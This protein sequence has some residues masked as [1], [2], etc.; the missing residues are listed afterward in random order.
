VQPSPGPPGSSSACVPSVQ[1]PGGFT[2]SRPTIRLSLV[3]GLGVAGAAL[4]APRP[5]A[6]APDAAAPADP[7]AD[8]QNRWDRTFKDAAK[9]Y[10]N[11]AKKYDTKLEATSAYVR[12]KVLQYLPDDPETRAFLG[13]VKARQADG[14]DDWERNDVIHDKLKDLTD[15]D[16]PK[17]TKFGTDLAAADLKIANWFKGLALK[18]T[19]NGNAKGASADAKWPE[20]AAQAWEKVLDVDD[21]PSSTNAAIVRVAEEAHKALNHPQFEKHY[22]SP[23][24]LKFLKVRA[25]R[26]AIGQKEHDAVIKPCDPCELD[27]KFAA[28]GLTGGGGKS[29]NFVFNATAGK[30]LSLRLAADCER[31]QMDLFAIYGYP[32]TVRERVALKKFNVVKDEKEY[33]QILVKGFGWSDAD[34]TKYLTAHFND[35]G[36]GAEQ[37][38][39]TSGGADADDAAMNITATVT[40]DAAQSIARSEVGVAGSGASGHVEDWLWQ[41]VAYDV[42]KRV[43]G[44]AI[45]VHGTFGKYGETIEARPGEDKW[46]ELARRLVV[47]GEDVPISRLHKLKLE[48][49]KDFGGPETIKGWALL[50]FLFETD[51][52]KAKKFVWNA[53]ANGT[54]AAALA[55]YPNDESAPDADKSMAKLDEEYRK[56]IVKGW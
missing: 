32:D 10:A 2:V 51:A 25:E 31:S 21:N 19:E 39:T 16:D 8:W 47:T 23:F 45:L 46:V 13:Y 44:T 50:Q 14:K 41:S 11:L 27:G 33:R 42:T 5:L 55:I 35:V 36:L 20:K 18:A 53:I 3:I 1:V 38:M 40:T 12:W 4:V 7:V 24:K 29:A 15:L 26:K 30:D 28:A 49:P 56:W 43:N 52:D 6:A 54:P 9:E 17:K 37:V 48:N 22:V 34:V